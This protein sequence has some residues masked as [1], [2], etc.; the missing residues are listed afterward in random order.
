MQ[1][2]KLEEIPDSFQ[3]QYS[4]KKDCGCEQ[5]ETITYNLQLEFC[6]GSSVYGNYIRK[7]KL[8]YK[9]STNLFWKQNPPVIGQHLGLG[10][11]ID[12]IPKLIENLKKLIK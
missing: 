8:Y 2:K 9:P 3:K 4:E 1:F 7:Y 6:G 10:V 5:H 12:E 11:E